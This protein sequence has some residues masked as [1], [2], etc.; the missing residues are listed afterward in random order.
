MVMLHFENGK[1]ITDNTDVAKYHCF[2][3]ILIKS[4]CNV[5]IYLKAAEAG[6]VTEKNIIIVSHIYVYNH[7]HLLPFKCDFLKTNSWR[8]VSH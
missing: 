5:K 2:F 7:H 3:L 6:H 8:I 4:N 1:K